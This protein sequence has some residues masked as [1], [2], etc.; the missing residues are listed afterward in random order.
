MGRVVLTVAVA[1]LCGC[2]PNMVREPYPVEVVREV[3]KPIPTEFTDPLAVPELPAG[4]LTVLT[5]V[6]HVKAWQAWAKVANDHR[7]RV[8]ELSKGQ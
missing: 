7:Q 2:Q 4:P 3:V 1:L 8:A 6:E 5:L